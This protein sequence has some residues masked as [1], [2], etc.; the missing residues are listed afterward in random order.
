MRCS[1]YALSVRPSHSGG[2]S[3]VGWPG[4]SSYSNEAIC[5]EKKL[6][7]ATRRTG[8]GV[9][10]C[11]KRFEHYPL[12]VTSLDLVPA[13]F[14][15][16]L[17][18]ADRYL[19]LPNASRFSR[20]ETQSIHQLCGPRYDIFDTHLPCNS[21]KDVVVIAAL[22]Y[23]LHSL[24]HG[25]D[26]RVELCNGNVAPL[27]WRRAGKNNVGVTGICVPAPIIHDDGFRLSPRCE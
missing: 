25:H 7:A 24:F 5:S 26:H 10:V 8:R 6:D 16:L 20:R 12:I 19:C 4:Q 9:R 18:G 3:H 2:S 11:T 22:S 13:L 21:R 1:G 23:R 27:K 14:F 17:A 15:Q